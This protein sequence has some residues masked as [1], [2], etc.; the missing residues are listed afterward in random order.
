MTPPTSVIAPTIPTSLSLATDAKALWAKDNDAIKTLAENTKIGSSRGDYLVAWMAAREKLW[1]DV[2]ESEKEAFAKQ[3][4]EAKE[5]KPSKEEISECVTFVFVLECQSD[6][7]TDIE[8]II[9]L[10]S[11]G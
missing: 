4:K 8:E 3:V 7:Y 11:S 9:W 1:E 5:R 6:S 10:R 2:P